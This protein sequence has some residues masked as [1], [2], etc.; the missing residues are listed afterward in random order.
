MKKVHSPT[1]LINGG[2]DAP[3]LLQKLNDDPSLVEIIKNAD[4][5]I[6]ESAGA[7]ILCDRQRIGFPEET[8]IVK[9]LGILHDTII[10]PH[11]I[12]LSRQSILQKDMADMHVHYGIGIDSSTGIQ[13]DPETFPTYTKIGE[14]VVELKVNAKE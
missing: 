2:K 11:Y 12:E 10:S 5:I 3:N 8:K 7:K 6:G 4:I 1:I 14:G 13:C 9:W